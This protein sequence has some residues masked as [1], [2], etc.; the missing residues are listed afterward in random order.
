MTASEHAAVV[1]PMVE[2]VVRLVHDYARSDDGWNRH[3]RRA[4]HEAGFVTSNGLRS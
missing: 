2:L 4:G 1:G 3:G